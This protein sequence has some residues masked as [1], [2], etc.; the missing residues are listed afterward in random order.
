MLTRKERLDGSIVDAQI[1]TTALARDLRISRFGTVVDEYGHE[2]GAVSHHYRLVRN[3]DLIAALDLASDKIGIDLECSGGR[4]HHG[5]SKY[6][7]FL[8]GEWKVPNDHSGI[9][10]NVTVNNGY[11]GTNKITGTT[12]T[13][14]LICTNG[15]AVGTILASM[16]Q[17]HIGPFDL[18][19]MVEQLLL[20][21]MEQAAIEQKRAITAGETP[22]E[23]RSHE[24]RS[25]EDKEVRRSNHKV[26]IEIGK[27]TPKKYQEPL[28]RAIVE[29][30]EMLGRTVWAMVQAI[31]EIAEHDMKGSIAA[32]AWRRRNQVKIMETVG[33]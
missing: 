30:E 26:L 18:M 32:N 9:R 3:A 1:H 31:A 6:T 14:R 2:C 22:Y 10:S 25:E 24:A 12:G 20:D 7:M 8:P 21:T 23:W 27:D 15:M 17:R 28:A 16:K 33:I 19:K 4:Y 13:F 11:G 5:R 29:S